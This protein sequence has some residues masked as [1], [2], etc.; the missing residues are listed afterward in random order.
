[1][2]TNFQI[3]SNPRGMS[4]GHCASGLG[5]FIGP[6]GTLVTATRR[7]KPAVW[8]SGGG[9]TN[10]GR[11][12]VAALPDGGRPR[13]IFVTRRGH[14]ANGLHGLVP[15]WRGMWVVEA[16]WSRRDGFTV[17]TSR[18][19][20]R[21]LEEVATPPERLMAAIQ[22]AKEKATCYHCRCLHWAVDQEEEEA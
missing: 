1:M 4:P 15:L 3:S 12:T 18:W 6:A 14:R 7:G 17:K 5:A 16:E 2:E 22:A 21:A 8:E 10:T 11:A 9:C 13:A 20:G 19:N